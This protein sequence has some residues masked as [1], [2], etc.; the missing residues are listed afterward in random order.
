MYPLPFGFPSYSGHH[1]TLKVEFP[2]KIKNKSIEFPVLYNRY[3][4]VICFI[5]SI[6]SVYVSIPVSQFL[7]PLPLFPLVVD[8]SDYSAF[9]KC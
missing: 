6:S 4:L 7:P 8:V 9:H 5:H 1:S 3:S 2:K